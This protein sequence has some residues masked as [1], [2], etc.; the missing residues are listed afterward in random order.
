MS[1][2]TTVGN[3]NGKYYIRI[4]FDDDSYPCIPDDDDTVRTPEEVAN[5]GLEFCKI[6]FQSPEEREYIF[7]KIMAL[8]PG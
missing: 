4:D 5:M 7:N 2:T 3:V 6:K 1:K 8:S